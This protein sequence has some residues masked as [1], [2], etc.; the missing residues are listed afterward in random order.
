MRDEGRL[1]RV[2]RMIFLFSALS[3]A[4]G[5]L[6]VY[7]PEQFMPPQFSTLGQQ[8]NESWVESLTYQGAD[9]R[10]IVRPPGLTDQPGGAATAGAIAAVLGLGL[11]L[12]QQQSRARYLPIAG[13]L[14]GLT[15]LYLTQVRSL[16]LMCLGAFAMMAALSL[17]RGRVRAAA[18]LVGSGGVLVLA[19][20]V[21]AT[22]VGGE[23]VE[24]RYTDIAQKGA[25][26][27]F[28]ENRGHF[29]SYTVGELLDEYPLG[30]GLGRWG[31]MYTYFGD[32]TDLASPPLYAEIQITGWLLDGGVPMWACYG[33]AIT[34]AVLLAYRLTRQ[35]RS[36]VVADL[37]TVALGLMVLVIGMSFAGPVFN[38]QVGIL[39]WFIVASLYGAGAGLLKRSP[40]PL[41]A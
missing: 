20:F 15:A 39:F 3:A 19:S 32:P 2:V 26:Q 18:W 28:R 16:L 27:T 5:I 22:A 31:M 41:P 21:W 14:L 24:S 7:F 30:A 10:M 17:R 1:L 38:T 4:L 34:V 13:T 11:T 37:A 40:A 33:G 9:G 25:V 8:M 35:K 36:A 29:V 6:Q 12:L 23:Q